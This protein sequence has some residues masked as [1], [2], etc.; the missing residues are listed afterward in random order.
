MECGALL[1]FSKI[2]K[3]NNMECTSTLSSSIIPKSRYLR[4]HGAVSLRGFFVSK[5]MDKLMP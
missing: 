1:F 2:P 5:N 4:L 3:S